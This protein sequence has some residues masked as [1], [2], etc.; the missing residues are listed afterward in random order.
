MIAAGPQEFHGRL[1]A[2][3]LG[4]SVALTTPILWEL[5][6]DIDYGKSHGRIQR[7]EYVAARPQLLPT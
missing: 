5:T 1:A 6:K 4:P 7:Q 3:L 2:F